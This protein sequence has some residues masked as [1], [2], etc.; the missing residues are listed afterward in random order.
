MEERKG[1]GKKGEKKS[2]KG[3]P[4][5]PEVQSGRDPIHQNAKERNGKQ[6]SL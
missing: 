5:S 3:G 1:K 6:R 2:I 4:F